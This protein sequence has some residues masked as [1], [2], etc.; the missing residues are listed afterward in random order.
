MKRWRERTEG[1][2]IQPGIT[3]Q[4]PNGTGAG[5]YAIWIR[6]RNWRLA[7]GWWQERKIIDTPMPG[8]Q[9]ISQVVFTYRWFRNTATWKEPVFSDPTR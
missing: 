7:F 2:V 8:G 9:C 4:R 3:W 6:I 1:D 5:R